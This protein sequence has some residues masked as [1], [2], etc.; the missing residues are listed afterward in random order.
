VTNYLVG[1]DSLVLGAYG[2]EV[3]AAETLD[4]LVDRLVSAKPRPNGL[5]VPTDLLTTRVYPLLYERGIRPGRDITIISCDNEEVRLSA[6]NPRPTSIDIRPEDIGRRAVRRLL[7]RLE[8]ADEPPS[9]IQVAPKL[10]L[11]T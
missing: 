4:K 2:R 8:N 5:F 3:V 10:V 1:N 7:M 6:L 11:P 9:R